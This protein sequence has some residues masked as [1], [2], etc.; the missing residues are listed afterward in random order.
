MGLGFYS[1]P[2]TL[3]GTLMKL[4]DDVFYTTIT[5]F[6]LCVIAIPVFTFFSVNKAEKR[7]DM[8]HKQIVEETQQFVGST[9]SSFAEKYGA[10]YKTY[11]VDG[12]K[13]YTFDINHVSITI[14]TKDGNIIKIENK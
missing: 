5:G 14:T 10:P 7:R 8:I 6:I 13:F 2:H 1:K 4:S 3:F 12:I 11:D 9:A